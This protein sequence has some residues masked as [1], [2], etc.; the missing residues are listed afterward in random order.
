[1]PDALLSTKLHI[2]RP[3]PALVHRPRL[4]ERLGAGLRGRLTL[5]SAPAGYG[6]TTLVSHWVA[7][8]G[9]ERR[10]TDASS[11]VFPPGD[12]EGA[13]TAPLQVAWLSLDASDNDLARFL[14]YLIAALQ[15]A[16]Q[17]AAAQQI[18]PG[19]GADIQPILESEADL[20]IERLLTALINDIVASGAR[21]VLVLDD[22]HVIH[23]FSIHRALDFLLDHLPH[24]SDGGVPVILLSRTDPPMPL[25]RLRVQRELTEIREADLRFTV[26]EADVFLNKLMALALSGQQV[27]DLEARTEGW[28]AALHLA[29]LHLADLSLQDRSG[30]TERIAALTGSHRYLIDYLGQEVMS[31]QTDEVR[32]FL[33]HTSILERFNVSLCDAILDEGRMTPHIRVGD[34]AASSSSTVART[35]VTQPSSP[36]SSWFV[37]RPSSKSAAILEHLK[38]ADLFLVALDDKGQW[39]R[40]H[41]L[42][43][44]FLL[45]RLHSTQPALVPEL[46]LRASGWYEGEG[47]VDEAI[48]HAL[49]GEDATRAARLLDENAEGYVFDAQISKLIR[50]ANRLPEEELC[51]FPR[52]CIYYAWALQFESRL[53][54]AESALA[55]AESHLDA[56]AATE[57]SRT[58]ASPTDASPSAGFSASQIA[59]H[60]RAVRAYM[61]LQ[62]GAYD[63]AIELARAALKALPEKAVDEL[64]VVRGA[65]TLGLGIGYFYLGQI[66]AAY[67]AVQ[68]AL[69]PNQRCG[70]RYALLSCIFLLIQIDLLSGALGQA[71]ADG[72]KGLLWIEQWSS[73]G[74]RRRPLA[75]LL[76]HIRQAMAVVHYERNELDEAARH[77]RPSTEYYEL[78]RSRYR[79]RG[80]ALLVDLYRA[81]GEIDAAREYLGKLAQT[82]LTPGFSLSFMPVAAVIAEKRLQLC[83]M[84][85]SL[86]DLLVDAARWA[87]TVDLQPYDTFNNRREYEFLVLAQIRIAQGRAAEVLP[88]LERLVAGTATRTGQL[89]AL[90]AVQAVAYHACGQVDAAQDAL[91]RALALGEPE[92]Y[93]RTFVDYGAPMADLLRQALGRGIAVDYVD[94]LLNAMPEQMK[95]ERRTTN[96]MDSSIVA[97]TNVGRPSSPHARVGFEPLNDREMQVLRLLA[98]GLSNRQIAEEL[99]LSIN[100]VKWYNRQIYDKLGVGRRGQA[101]ARAQELG[102]L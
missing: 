100:T 86:A 56:T 78:V 26:E 6:K 48:E 1:M 45:S 70:N 13:E 9:L 75:R 28:I 19:I 102:L 39:Y 20:E 42:F 85:P 84:D 15:K 82:S 61:A 17:Q 63:L 3:H 66:E 14:S 60:A 7:N 35:D 34:E 50:L 36:S 33:L 79:V 58:D 62:R 16:A 89:I 80:Y 30:R 27:A 68:S 23:E 43:R 5:V 29:A 95:D 51:R 74:G 10:G 71:L 40:Y 72:R 65:A 52:L 31:R 8:Q 87:E 57:A 54:A 76:A 101:V 46:Y 98:A 55:C 90:L 32:T 77:I 49:A 83:R 12:G 25:G 81:L 2:P 96:V 59:Q 21:L 73:A 47:M 93:V 38:H 69:S 64:W 37:V 44:D 91:S 41:Q 99:Y 11:V 22:Y 97:H 88:L 24:P 92:G 18:D 53:E 4:A 94:R 67:R